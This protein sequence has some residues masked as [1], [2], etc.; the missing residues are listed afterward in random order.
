MA[1][2][3]PLFLVGALAVAVPIVIHFL[4]REPEARV[5][6]A[7]VHMLEHAPVEHAD[8]RRLRQLLLLALR[9]L[10]LLLLA[11]AFARPFLSGSGAAAAS[12]VTVVALDTSL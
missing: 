1:F 2:L 10:A 11:L 5:Q 7:A 4:R 12:G 3:S 8:R 9:C 6:F